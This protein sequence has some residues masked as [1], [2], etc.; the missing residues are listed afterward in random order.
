MRSANERPQASRGVDPTPDPTNEGL[1]SEFMEEMEADLAAATQQQ[2]AGERGDVRNTDVGNNSEIRNGEGDRNNNGERQSNE[3]MGRRGDDSRSGGDRPRGDEPGGDDFE[4][5]IGEARPIDGI[6]SNEDQPDWGGVNQ[7][8]L[9]LGEANYADGISEVSEDLPNAREIS[10]AVVQQTG[11][12]PNSF[13]L[14]DLLWVWGQFVDHDIDLTESGETEYTPIAVPVGDP[15]FDPNGEGDATIPFFR[16][17]PSE[18]TGESTPREYVNE[19]TAFI[20]ASMVYGSD[21]ETA[22]AL[23]ADGGKLILDD[24]ELLQI[25]DDGN[26]LA[27]DVRAAENVALTSMQTLFAREHNRWVDELAEANPTLSNDELYQAARQMV[28][29]E[30]QAITFN[31]FLPLLVGAEA[32]AAY[33]GYDAAVN[34][35]ISVE[36]STAVFR[37]GHSLLSPE[38]QRLEEDGSVIDSGNLALS[39]A[40]FS[41]EEIAENGG[42]DPILRGLAD[43]TAQE[44][45]TQIVE[46]VRSALFGAP[47]DGGLDL[48]VLNIER[49]RDLGMPSYN[50]LRE[51]VGLERAAD[52]SD[53]TSDAELATALQEVYGD[54]DLVEAWIGGLAEDPFGDGVVGE[55]F[56]TV[57][58]DQFERLRDGDP[59]WSQGSDLPEEQLAALWDTSLANVI[60]W[61]SEIESIQDNALLAYNRIGGTGE[62][63]DL[64]GAL[65]GNLVSSDLILGL[66]G[67]D[68]LSG[69]EGDDQL[70]GGKGQDSLSG[71]DGNDILYGD[72]GRDEL[73]GGAGDDM[74]T[75]GKDSDTFIFTGIFGD[76]VITDFSTGRGE[77]DAIL[78]ESDVFA[79][80]ADLLDAAVQSGEDV[81]V[82]FGDAGS[83]T[84]ESF[85]LADLSEND[86][87]LI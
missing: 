12:E 29:A 62:N 39:D 31:E 64:T 66:A 1:I 16:V 33:E 9:R 81:V 76:D 83:I 67:D 47:G 43:G 15:A 72:D 11:D 46:D 13:G 55:L 35:G 68:L 70:E 60:E 18:G 7:T 3:G 84:L 77:D 27:G 61:N 44:L 69:G 86:W 80:E 41:P 79:D 50:D 10:N 51:A 25:T 14:S 6:G 37:F 54:V 57:I 23:R 38:I 36:F 21:E 59:F 85:N 53:I 22:A 58:I 52:F 26:V 42:I 19:I 34:P 5:V 32:I 65:P 78:V 71:D 63:D 75:G 28:E 73:S 56:A 40:F 45:D 4:V 17:D 30:I 87:M 24:E 82:E 8:L 2:D 74:L 20:D 49:G 48:A